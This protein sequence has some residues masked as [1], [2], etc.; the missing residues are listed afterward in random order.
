MFYGYAQTTD[1]ENAIINNA[2]SKYFF[3][4]NGRNNSITVYTAVNVI[5][6]NTYLPVYKVY[7]HIMC[8]N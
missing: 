6:Q 5:L 8:A 3:Q 1:L 7:I 2:L 4:S